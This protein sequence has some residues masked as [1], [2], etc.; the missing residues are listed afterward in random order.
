MVSFSEHHAL[1]VSMV[2]P[3]LFFDTGGTMVVVS[4][5]VHSGYSFWIHNGYQSTCVMI[6]KMIDKFNPLF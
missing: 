5:S 3:P 4:G 2:S 1:P 6:A